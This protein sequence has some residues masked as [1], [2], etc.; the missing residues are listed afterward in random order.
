MFGVSVS[1]LDHCKQPPDGLLVREGV[2]DLCVVLSLSC[3]DPF[4]LVIICARVF[5]YVC[6]LVCVSMFNNRTSVPVHCE[7]L[8]L[9]YT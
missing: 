3:K 5:V 8:R 6:V 9:R 7:L 2:K 4:H 1:S